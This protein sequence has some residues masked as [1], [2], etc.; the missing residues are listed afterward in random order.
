[1]ARKNTKNTGMNWVSKKK[2]HN[3]FQKLE[4]DDVIEK[5]TSTLIHD[6]RK[7]SKDHRINTR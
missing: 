7:I 5:V 4:L 6:K 2:T 1:M 3:S